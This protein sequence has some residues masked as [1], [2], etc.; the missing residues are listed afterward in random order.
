[1]I[2]ELLNKFSDREKIV[3]FGH[4]FLGMKWIDIAKDMKIS[5]ERVRQLKEKSLE[6]ADSDLKLRIAMSMSSGEEKEKIGYISSAIDN[7]RIFGKHK[8]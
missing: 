8:I 2:E 5:R 7:I 6:K 3:I 4:W 1:M